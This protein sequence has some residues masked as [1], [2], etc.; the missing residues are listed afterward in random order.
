MDNTDSLLPITFAVGDPRVDNNGSDFT[1]IAL[2]ISYLSSFSADFD[3][4]SWIDG[5]AQFRERCQKDCLAFESSLYQVGLTQQRIKVQKS[6]ILSGHFDSVDKCLCPNDMKKNCKS[7]EYGT[8]T[9]FKKMSAYRKTG[10]NIP[11]CFMKNKFIV[12]RALT[13]YPYK[14]KNYYN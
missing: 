14:V 4:C 5:F 10:Q 13:G 7:M 3:Q 11:T 2:I 1:E 6:Q 12:H 8:C 9:S